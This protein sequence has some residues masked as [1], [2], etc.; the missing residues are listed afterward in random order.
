MKLNIK[1]LKPELQIEL[2]TNIPVSQLNRLARLADAKHG[3]NKKATAKNIVESGRFTCEIDFWYGLSNEADAEFVDTQNPDTQYHRELREWN[4]G[5]E[6]EDDAAQQV[7]ELFASNITR[8]PTPDE[9][10]SLPISPEL[11]RYVKDAISG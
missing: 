5:I 2:L 3:K 6:V 9:E 7:E 10:S 4:D 8:F 11:E 1:K